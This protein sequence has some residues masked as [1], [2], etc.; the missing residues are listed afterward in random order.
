MEFLS[1]SFIHL[2]RPNH[3][4]EAAKNATIHTVGLWHEHL[5][6]PSRHLFDKYSYIMMRWASK[7]CI[8]F[9]THLNFHLIYRCCGQP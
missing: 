3:A 4:G 9:S 5:Q 1:V 8:V 2:F 7:L 6:N